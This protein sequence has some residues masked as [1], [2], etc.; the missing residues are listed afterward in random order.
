M[1]NNS[2]RLK[3]HYTYT[4]DPKTGLAIFDRGELVVSQPFNSDT[5]AP[6]TD[7]TEALAWAIA[8]FG[9]FFTP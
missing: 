1:I 9:D 2:M 4:F 3:E 6:F 8:H 5:G 7:D